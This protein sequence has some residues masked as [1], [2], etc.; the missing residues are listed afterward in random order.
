MINKAAEIFLLFMYGLCL[1]HFLYYF[2]IIL[3]DTIKSL[4]KDIKRMIKEKE[5]EEDEGNDY[6]KQ[7]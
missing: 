2:F 7:N 1:L 4:I 6:D 5:W 3:I